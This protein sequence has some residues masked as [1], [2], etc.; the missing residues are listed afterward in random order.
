MVTILPT[1]DPQPDTSPD[2]RFTAAV[3]R[4]RS[5]EGGLVDDPKDPGGITHHGIAI[6]FAKRWSAAD[7]RQLAAAG[8]AVPG[9]ITPDWI[10]G[11]TWD[12]AAVVYRV[13]WWDRYEYGAL[14]YGVGAKALDAAVNLGP[15]RA[16]TALQRACR[17]HGRRLTEDGIL[18]P[19]SRAAIA[20]IG[21]AIIPAYRS[22]IAALYREEVVRDPRD[23]RYIRG[24]LIRA[25]DEEA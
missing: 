17:A 3:G 16:H 1:G 22:E 21:A 24:W 15:M 23:Q 7:R 4:L 2:A 13:L 20:E 19:R 18:G 10:R 12:E 6:N 11:L 14:P 25:Y 9:T 8:L 5:R